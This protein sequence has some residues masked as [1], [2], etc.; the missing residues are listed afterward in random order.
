[1]T[2]TRAGRALLLALALG[3][4]AGC[5]AGRQASRTPFISGKVPEYDA[6]YRELSQPPEESRRAFVD[7]IR[8]LAAAATP[9]ATRA[10]SIETID[11]VLKD[12]LARLTL[13]PSPE[14][15]VRVA[16]AYR[17][18]GI[19]DQA[20]DHLDAALRLKAEYAPA[21]DVTAR[22]WRDGG[23]LQQALGYAHRAV[24]AAP[25]SA[26]ARNTLG[27]I[28]QALGQKD[29]A[30]RAYRAALDLDPGASWARKNYCALLPP[31]AGSRTHVECAGMCLQDGPEA[32]K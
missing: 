24:H 2:R 14:N 16:I 4:L 27:T 31:D 13:L 30:R 11:G 20:F 17:Q 22:L 23:F 7:R 26:A 8:R 6:V 19:V 29:E 9:N 12:S 32:G 21:L 25:Y 5:A 18:L 10:A 3:A 28:L 15:H 1:M